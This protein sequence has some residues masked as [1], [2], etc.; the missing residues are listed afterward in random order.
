VSDFVLIHSLHGQ[1]RY[2]ELGRWPLSG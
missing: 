1:S 2:I